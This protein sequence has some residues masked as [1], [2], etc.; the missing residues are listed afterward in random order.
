MRVSL[1]VA[2]LVGSGLC[3]VFEHFEELEDAGER[4][5]AIAGLGA[6]ASLETS[7]WSAVH[8]EDEAICLPRRS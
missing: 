7:V 5:P 2:I 8:L 4:C 1:P 3:M 6:H